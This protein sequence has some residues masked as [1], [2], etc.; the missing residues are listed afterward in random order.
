MLNLFYFIYSSIGG[1]DASFLA[2]LKFYSIVRVVIRVVANTLMPIYFILISKSRKY[3]INRGA[4]KRSPQIII[5]LTS[6]PVRIGRVWIVIE[7][8]LRQS[9]KPDRIVLWLSKAQ[10][11]S[12]DEVPRN[13][14]KFKERGLEIYLVDGD[15]RSHKKYYYVMKYSPNDIIITVD[16]DIFYKKDFVKDMFETSLKNPNSL[17]CNYAYWIKYD[18]E[19]NVSPYM[20]W[21]KCDYAKATSHEVFFGSGGGVLFPPKALYSDVLN[22]DLAYSLCPLADD[23]WLNSMAQLNDLSIVK[24]RNNN[25]LLP[26]MNWKDITLAEDNLENN[27]NDRQIQAVVDYYKDMRLFTNK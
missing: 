21:C 9:L 4:Q 15:I 11:S 13:L 2:R 23:V 18:D 1:N 16:D 12:I 7:T 27:Q 3:S 19:G 22:I 25:T 5:S 20:Q 14:L 10:F 6:F 24:L 17:I 8:L 26:V